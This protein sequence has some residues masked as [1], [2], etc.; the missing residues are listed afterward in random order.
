VSTLKRPEP[1][2]SATVK[3]TMTVWVRW[4]ASDRSIPQNYQKG[5]V[6]EVPRA[7]ACLWYLLAWC[8]PAPG[9]V[10]TLAEKLE[11]GAAAL[12]E[13][14]TQRQNRGGDPESWYR[15]PANA[16]AL[17][18]LDSLTRAEGPGGDAA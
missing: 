2:I 7:L 9:V 16:R 13:L 1:E 5:T 11:A 3:V 8:E 15:I 14:E 6:A 17:A 12:A 4:S 10:F 18:R